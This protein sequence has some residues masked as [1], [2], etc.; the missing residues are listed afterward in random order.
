MIRAE[1]EPSAEIDFPDSEEEINRRAWHKALK[2]TVPYLFVFALADLAFPWKHHWTRCL[3]YVVFEIAIIL[4][5]FFRW[6]N[7]FRFKTLLPAK[8]L[9]GLRHPLVRIPAILLACGVLGGGLGYVLP[10]FLT[11]S[12]LP[13]IQMPWLRDLGVCVLVVALVC[14]TV[15]FVLSRTR[16]GAAFV[17]SIAPGSHPWSIVTKTYGPFFQEISLPEEKSKSL[18]SLILKKTMAGAKVGVSLMTCRGDAPKRAALLAKSKQEMAA[19]ENEIRQLLGETHYSAFLD[20]LK[21]IPNRAII[22]PLSLDSAK[23]QQLLQAMAA[24][25]AKYPWN[26]D[27]SRRQ[28]INGNAIDPV[29]PGNVE[30]FE[31][32]EK[33]F[34]AQFLH[35]A[36]ELLTPV[37]LAAFD[38]TQQRQLRTQISQLKLAAKFLAPPPAKSR[39]A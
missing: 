24:A 1:E 32:E 29:T 22:Q 31:R 36:R 37:E 19:G 11:G 2:F 5:S 28:E 13:P 34:A 35:Q 9:T 17:P 6:Y 7:L 23:Q 25:R 30:I 27:L 33:A 3:A 16:L 18:T 21:T 14:G 10:C 20:Y 38:K 12:P 15:F 39:Q 8:P 26:T 4:W